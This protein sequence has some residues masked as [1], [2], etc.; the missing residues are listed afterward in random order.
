M[1]RAQEPESAID[2]RSSGTAG[3]ERT[4]VVLRTGALALTDPAPGETDR[5]DVRLVLARLVADQLENPPAYGGETPAT[6]TAS[7]LADLADREH[8]G[9][10]FAVVGERETAAI[11]LAFA[12][13]SGGRIDRVALIAAPLPAS[14]LERDVAR[15]ALAQVQARVLLL[16]AAGDA[17]SREAALWYRDALS[18]AEVSEV[19]AAE[20]DSPDGRLG[21]GDAWP[22]VLAHVGEDAR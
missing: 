20:I 10:A 18:S 14:P 17:A 8:P 6:S 9:S 13:A 16:V 2:Y 11:A 3:A 19:P 22:R 5:H 21:I 4:V 7:A 15:P 1:T 12:A